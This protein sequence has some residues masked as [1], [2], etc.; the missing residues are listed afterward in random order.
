MCNLMI[1]SE[2]VAWARE[3]YVISYINETTPLNESDTKAADLRYDDFPEVSQ[4]CDRFLG[5]LD[6]AFAFSRQQKL[7]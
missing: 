4:L 7:E 6:A 2:T 3:A 5:K 1:V